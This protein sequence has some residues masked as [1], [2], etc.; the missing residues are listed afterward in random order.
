M[1]WSAESESILIDDED[2]AR[3]KHLVWYT[4]RRRN[5]SY[6]KTNF[7]L[8]LHRFIM[9]LKNGDG[10]YVDHINGNGLDNRKVN[11][12]VC[13]ASQNGANVPKVNETGFRGVYL[14]IDGKKYIARIRLS[15]YKAH[16]G[17]FDTPEQAARAYDKAAR[18]EYGPY[19]VLNFEEE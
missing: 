12:R 7:G 1:E 2:Y 17:S 3:I 4:E 15:G 18:A 16:L 19:A 9:G 13:S 5:T 14:R 6:V 10:Q 8:Y 11:L